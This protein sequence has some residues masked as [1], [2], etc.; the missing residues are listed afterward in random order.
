[1]ISTLESSNLPT[2]VFCLRIS[3]CLEETPHPPSPVSDLRLLQLTEN[4]LAKE[5]TDLIGTLDISD[6]SVL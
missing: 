6:M 5:V 3:A 2:G 4:C 1:M